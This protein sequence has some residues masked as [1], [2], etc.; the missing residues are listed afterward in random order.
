VYKLWIR[1]G[2]GEK[3]LKQHRDLVAVASNNP[4]SPYPAGPSINELD[5]DY[6][7]CSIDL[8]GRVD[9]V[10]LVQPNRILS[11]VGHAVDTEDPG[12]LGIVL[13]RKILSISLFHIQTMW[14]QHNI[15]CEIPP[16]QL[17]KFRLFQ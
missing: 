3:V 5:Q 7:I 2:L 6:I 17:V 16:L 13:I 12:W 15:V 10:R 11:A 8:Y 9:I 4:S 1:Y 14:N